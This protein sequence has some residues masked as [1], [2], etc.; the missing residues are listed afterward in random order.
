MGWE[1]E[2]CALI[3]KT[4]GLLHAPPQNPSIMAT[5]KFPR[6]PIPT[7][8]APQASTQI[9]PEQPHRKYYQSEQHAPISGNGRTY[10]ST[11]ATPAGLTSALT[12]SVT[13]PLILVCCPD[14]GSTDPDIADIL[15][16][17]G[18]KGGGKREWFWVRGAGSLLAKFR[19]GSEC[20]QKSHTG[21]GSSFRG[22]GKRDGN[23]KRL[24]MQGQT[25]PGSR[26]REHEPK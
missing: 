4:T 17:L 22:R 7:Y 26:G 20:L 15:H 13:D 3:S 14:P 16:N 23:E 5:S 1:R 12:G 19:Q 11:S 18:W 6:T 21:H 2:D 9:S 8:R 10:A 24:A 25:S